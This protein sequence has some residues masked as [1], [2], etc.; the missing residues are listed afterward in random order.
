MKNPPVK[1]LRRRRNRLGNQLQRTSASPVWSSVCLFRLA[2]FGCLLAVCLLVWL[3][4][5]FK[6]VVLTVSFGCLVGSLAG[7]LIGWSVGRLV[8]WLV[9]F[10]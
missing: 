6:L 5:L 10:L 9:G 3:F 7:C 1:I 2:V 8:G 4:C